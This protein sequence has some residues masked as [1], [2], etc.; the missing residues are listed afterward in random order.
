MDS[1]QFSEISPVPKK[2]V[3]VSEKRELK[4]L[5]IQKNKVLLKQ[6]LQA[7]HFYTLK[8]FKKRIQERKLEKV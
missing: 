1:P 3:I 6:I 4:N 2:K 5:L 8:Q 7:W